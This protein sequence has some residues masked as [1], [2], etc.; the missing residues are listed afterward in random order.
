MLFFKE[1]VM[2]R[3]LLLIL[4]YSLILSTGC[5]KDPCEEVSC[6]NGGICMDGECECPEGFQ[7]NFCESF[8]LQQYFGTY[9]ITYEGCFTTSENH[10]VS[11][12]QILGESNRFLIHHL[13]DYDCPTGNIQLEAISSSNAI[14]IEEQQIDCGDIVYTF[15]GTG[16]FSNGSTVTLDFTVRYDAGGFEQVD[17]CRAILG[18]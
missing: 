13:G 8:D 15:E 1:V 6:E 7:G 14:T 11:L 5:K 3:S 4:V 9:N 17:Q 16:T 12:E 10:T 2:G 18:K